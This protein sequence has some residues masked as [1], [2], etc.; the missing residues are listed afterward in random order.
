MFNLKFKEIES[1]YKFMIDK[2]LYC[3]IDSDFD[4]I[5]EYEQINYYFLDSNEILKER[6]LY[7]GKTKI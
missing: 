1:E 4:W 7:Y 6:K 2:N 3:R 5:K